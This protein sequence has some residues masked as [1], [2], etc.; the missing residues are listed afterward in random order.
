MIWDAIKG[1]LGAAGAIFGYFTKRSDLKNTK[2]MKKAEEAQKETD[3][4]DADAKAIRDR[5][6]DASRNNLS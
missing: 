4:N 1:L 5:N 2:E 6:L 3:A